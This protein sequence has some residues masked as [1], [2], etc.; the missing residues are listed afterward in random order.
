MKKVFEPTILRTH[1]YQE[2]G[3]CAD[4]MYQIYT[5]KFDDDCPPVSEMWSSL[6]NISKAFLILLLQEE[7]FTLQHAPTHEAIIRKLIEH[8][9]YKASFGF[10]SSDDNLPGLTEDER[11]EKRTNYQQ[12]KLQLLLDKE[13][14]P[15]T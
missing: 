10:Y 12:Q 3:Y 5:G 2:G 7:H 13:P 6:D 8:M 15:Q 4:Y 14:N 11:S 9:A 1:L